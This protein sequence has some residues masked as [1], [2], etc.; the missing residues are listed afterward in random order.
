VRTANSLADYT[1]RELIVHQLCERD[2]AGIIGELSR[3]L[4]RWEC[5]PDVLSFYQAALNQE[6]LSD[7]AGG[8]GLAVA[9]ARM[10]G[11]KRLLF[12]SGRT[13]SPVVWSAN[14]SCRVQLIFLLAVPGGETSRYLQLL[15]SLAK[16]GQNP[17]T[18][19]QL[20]AA[21]DGAAIMAVLKEVP[22]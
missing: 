9:H 11:I 4:G 7:S 22:L 18:V 20:L 10:G 2:A 19:A 8:S 5:V 6:L 14:N 12:A 17:E 16:L 15:A 13:A 1:R 21:P 3:V